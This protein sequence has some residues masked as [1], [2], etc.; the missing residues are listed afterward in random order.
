MSDTPKSDDA[1]G[2]PSLTL[3]PCDLP[4][5][6]TSDMHASDGD[7][8]WSRCD[9]CGKDLRHDAWRLCLRV[10]RYVCKECPK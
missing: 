6:H 8:F 4:K 3:G 10:A 9:T 5:G 1:C 2:V 7:G